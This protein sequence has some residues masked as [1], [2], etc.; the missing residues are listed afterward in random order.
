MPMTQN[1]LI[2][3]IYSLKIS[4]KNLTQV[5]LSGEF[6]LFLRMFRLFMFF[7]ENMKNKTF[8]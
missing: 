8:C 3:K 1:T 7:P 4:L 5:F 6:T 2:F